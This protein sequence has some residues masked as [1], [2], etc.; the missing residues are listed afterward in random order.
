MDQEFNSRSH[1]ESLSR[2]MDPRSSGKNDLGPNFAVSNPE[3]PFRKSTKFPASHKLGI[4]NNSSAL[5]EEG[6]LS[7][8]PHT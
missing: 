7:K 8:G 6:V 5:A 1:Y 3:N 4:M 2:T